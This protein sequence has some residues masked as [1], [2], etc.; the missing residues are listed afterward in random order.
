VEYGWFHVAKMDVGGAGGKEQHSETM[1][2][3]LYA[4]HHAW[5]DYPI[6][7]GV[8]LLGLDANRRAKANDSETAWSW[9]IRWNK[10]HYWDA[11]GVEHMIDGIV[12]DTDYKQPEMTQFLEEA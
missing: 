6:P 1:T 5:V 8:T 4:C 3:T 11:D 12:R 9:W 7:S 10:L 2:A